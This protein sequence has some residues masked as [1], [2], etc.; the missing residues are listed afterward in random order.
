[1]LKN[2]VLT[3]SLISGLALLVAVPVVHGNIIDTTHG[4][5]TGSFEIGGFPSPPSGGFLR[6]TSGSFS[7]WNVGG[8]GID[9]L[10]ESRFGADDGEYS[11]DLQASAPGSVFLDIPTAVGEV[12]ELSFASARPSGFGATSGR[13]TA[14]DLSQDFAPAIGG[15][16]AAPNWVQHTFDFTASTST[17]TITFAALTASQGSFGPMLDDVVVV[18]KQVPA[19]APALLLGGGLLALVWLRSR[20]A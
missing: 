20:R 12:Y 10:K 11:V 13:V 18:V 15:S 5:G 16:L 4:A 9:W 6:R 7:N 2:R 17:T 14:G 8:S 3:L 19:P 1:M